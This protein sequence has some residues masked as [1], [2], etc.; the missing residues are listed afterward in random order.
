MKSVRNIVRID[1][2]KCNG[3]GLCVTACAEGAI[4]LVDGKARLVSEVYCDGL[5]ACLGE[6]PQG[7]I[8]VERRE[9]QAFDR[10]AVERHLERSEERPM[11][12]QHQPEGGGFQGC[13]GSMMRMLQAEPDREQEQQAGPPVEEK[14]SLR[15]WPVQLKLVPVSAPYFQGAR[16]LLSAD[17]V[18]F[19]YAGFHREFL[20]GRVVLV[21]CPKLDDCE[22]Y[23]DKL[24]AIFAQNEI[25]SVEVVFMEV[26]CCFGMANMVQLALEASGKRIPASF[27]PD[28][29]RGRNPRPP[30]G[31][32]KGAQRGTDTA[33]GTVATRMPGS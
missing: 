26:P 27:H 15:N 16:L 4:R 10:Q 20:E 19:S 12:K 21:G 1:E 22:L 24:T 5:G 28:R 30:R 33:S 2:D 6:C 18:P 17:C 29:H 32:L 3:C 13:P 9:A 25:E 23:L 7:A 8:T 14:S 31:F 11:A